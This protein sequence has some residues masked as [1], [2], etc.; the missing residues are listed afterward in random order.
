MNGCKDAQLE[1]NSLTPEN[2]VLYLIGRFV[3]DGKHSFDE[4]GFEDFNAKQII[5]ENNKQNEINDDAFEK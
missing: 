4:K 3:I 2:H 1:W 5:S